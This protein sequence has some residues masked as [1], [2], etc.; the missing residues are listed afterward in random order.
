MSM[1]FYSLVKS[2]VPYAD[3]KGAFGRQFH[4]AFSFRFTGSQK[5][6]SEVQ[7]DDVRSSK[8]PHFWVQYHKLKH[9][10]YSLLL[11]V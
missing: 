2:V 3:T 1:D 8:V 11:H 4:A 9:V 10:K 6:S 5:K 7:F